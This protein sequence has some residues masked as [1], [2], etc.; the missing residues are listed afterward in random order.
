MNRIR[1]RISF[2]KMNKVY[3]TLSIPNGFVVILG[4]VTN[5]LLTGRVPALLFDKLILEKRGERG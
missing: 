4:I 3:V 5:R 1:L 2:L